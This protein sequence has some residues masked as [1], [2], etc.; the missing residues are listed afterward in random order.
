MRLAVEGLEVLVAPGDRV[1]AGRCVAASP[2]GAPHERR[3]HSP[4]SGRIAAAG[5]DGEVA[6]EGLP[7]P[8]GA[9]T[10]RGPCAVTPED[11][12]GAARQAG[13]VGLGGGSFP[14]HVKLSPGKPVELVIANGC[15]S[16]PYL[17]CDARVLAEH[18]D[19]VECG[20]RLAMRAAGAPRGEIV[21]GGDYP[22]GHERALVRDLLGREVPE[23]GLPRDAGAI[24]I[25]VQTARALHQA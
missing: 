16:E 24:V 19:E 21:T 20:L 22:A 3:V 15:E 12:V 5:G 8:A 6:I 18:R 11:V 1:E 14:T 17:A 10:H 13:L 25:N 2:P 4:Y 7:A 9:A 23:G